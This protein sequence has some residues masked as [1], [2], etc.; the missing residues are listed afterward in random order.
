MRKSIKYNP[1]D[2]IRN[3]DEIQKRI[4]VLLYVDGAYGNKHINLKKFVKKARAKL[5]VNNEK[6]IKK[7][8]RDLINKGFVSEKNHKS[9]S[10][11]LSKSAKD[12]LD[13]LVFCI[14]MIQTYSELVK[15]MEI[16]LNENFYSLTSYR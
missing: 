12:L 16:F 6:I 9:R 11:Y 7:K 5:K 4:L 8:L 10:V 15:I 13:K 14:V 1:D 2:S 3:L